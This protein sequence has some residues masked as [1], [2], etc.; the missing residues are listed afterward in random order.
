MD[1][2]TVMFDRLHVLTNGTL[3]IQ[4]MEE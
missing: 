4:T 2:V 1:F 3:Y